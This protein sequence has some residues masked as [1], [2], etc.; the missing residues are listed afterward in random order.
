MP[1]Q[2]KRPG[3]QTADARIAVEEH[4]VQSHRY[5]PVVHKPS[6]DGRPPPSRRQPLAFAGWESLSGGQFE[7]HLGGSQ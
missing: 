6:G 1:P 2:F 5:R 7:D 4:H 3:G